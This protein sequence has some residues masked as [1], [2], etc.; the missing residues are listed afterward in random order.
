MPQCR[1]K[2]KQSGVQ[3][4]RM[5]TPGCEVCNIHGGKSLVG[6]ASPHFRTGRRS[7]NL[8]T[9]MMPDYE[10]AYQDSELLQ[11]RH[12]IAIT[13]AR[14]EDLLARVDSGEA[15]E[16]W[17]SL[18]QTYAVAENARAQMNVLQSG[19]DFLKAKQTFEEAYETIGV[20]IS[21]GVQDYQA[22]DEVNRIIEQRRRL[23]ETEVKTLDKLQQF[24]TA[25]R[26]NLFVT[27]L[28]N[29][30]RS[31]V[32]DPGILAGIAADVRSI[33]AGEVRHRAN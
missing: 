19:V 6:I 13:D 27:T 23:S 3:C 24:V 10:Q 26:A 28:L 16:L 32:T 8:P 11:L 7:R 5:A 1:A 14:R 17:R 25:E 2:S 21:E 18:R 20:L 29:A 31:R 12:E 22:W 33:T 15:G 4:R 9:R 30:V